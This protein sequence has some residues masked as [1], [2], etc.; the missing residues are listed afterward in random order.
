MKND[1]S[2]CPKTFLFFLLLFRLPQFCRSPSPRFALLGCQ[3]ILWAELLSALLITFFVA[4]LIQKTDSFLSWQRTFFNVCY[5]SRCSCYFCRCRR[6]SNTLRSVPDKQCCVFSCNWVIDIQP[7]NVNST[8]NLFASSDSASDV[9][10]NSLVGAGVTEDS[11]D[12]VGDGDG[13]SAGVTG[14]VSVGVGIGA[15]GL[16]EGIGV[17][18]ISGAGIGVVPMFGVG[19]SV[20]SA[21]G[22]GC[23]VGFAETAAEGRFVFPAITA[24]RSASSLASSSLLTQN[25]LCA[26]SAISSFLLCHRQAEPSLPFHSRQKVLYVLLLP[27]P[28]L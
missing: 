16:R 28:G 25:G 11:A 14:G 7:V 4:L 22:V 21:F 6:V 20:T 9:A 3:N 27:P 12:S 5:I 24:S 15:V 13:C 10:G 18:T 2:L 1:L 23:F 8:R 19:L 26:L 17:A